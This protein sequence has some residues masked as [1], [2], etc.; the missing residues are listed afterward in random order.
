MS[1]NEGESIAN[2][3]QNINQTVLSQTISTITTKKQVKFKLGLVSDRAA[4]ASLEGP[5][6]PFGKLIGLPKIKDPSRITNSDEIIEKLCQLTYFSKQILIM[7]GDYIG[8][9][10]SFTNQYQESDYK[11]ISTAL[12]SCQSK[13]SKLLNMDLLFIPR[14]C[15]HITNLVRVFCLP[16]NGH[17]LLRTNHIGLGRQD[18]V[19]LSAYITRQQFFDAHSNAPL[20]DENES[21]RQCLRSTCLLAGLKQKN[22]VVL[23][24][25]HL[26]S[27]QMINQLYIF[28]CE[29]TYPGLYS[30]EELIRIAAALSPSLPT[31]RR[32]IKTN[33]VLKTFYAR[34]RKRLHLVI[35][36]N[37][38][39]KKKGYF[40]FF[41]FFNKLYSMFRT[42]TFGII[43]FMLC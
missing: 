29:G 16:N 3:S 18:L 35:L 17:A 23:V 31:T 12:H 38:Q 33:A 2:T 11:Q 26:L 7:H 34:V 27:D 6:V 41:H 42:S 10:D 30:N 9:R 4:L 14:T 1:T 28:T 21:V 24:R 20:I 40:F 5:I 19:Q 8:E 25:E 39:R 43:I 22:A 32:V 15:R 36:E 13:M 37:S